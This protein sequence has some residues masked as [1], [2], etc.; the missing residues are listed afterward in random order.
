MS[1]VETDE[2]S[3]ILERARNLSAAARITLARPFWRL[4]KSRN[5]PDPRGS[6]LAIFDAWMPVEKALG[7]LETGQPPDDAIQRIVDEERG[8]KYGA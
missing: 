3:E 2:L 1:A 8:E 7:L 5:R 4:W 6:C